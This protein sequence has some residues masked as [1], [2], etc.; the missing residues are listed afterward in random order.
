MLWNVAAPFF[1]G[2]SIWIDDF[3]PAGSFDFAKIAAPEVQ[4]GDWHVRRTRAT[5]LT[6]WA[7]HW[8][9]AKRALGADG[10]VTVFPQLAATANIQRRLFRRNIPMVA[11]CFNI[12]RFPHGIERALVRSAFRGIERI[13]VHSRAEVRLVSDLVGVAGDTVQFVPLQRAPIPVLEEEDQTAPFIV[14]MG[15]AN[16]D[17]ATLF[18]A[19]RRSRLPLTVVASAVA[20]GD[21]RPPANVTLL[22]GL[23]AE[24][25]WRL[26]QRARFSIVPLR[27]VAIASGQVTVIEAMRMNRAVI[28]TVSIG[29]E[30]YIADGVTGVLVP[31]G[32]AAALADRMTLL[33]D[34]RDRRARLARQA[35]DFAEETLSDRS[36]A[37]ALVRIMREA[38]RV[39][40]GRAG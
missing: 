23:T 32:D 14:S 10:L 9:H 5:P 33:W 19:A 18:E 20:I 11:W 4:A 15:S 37:A 13:V 6:T 22:S 26:A 30:D 27:D 39:H 36:A 2:D 17:Y 16:R 25:C 38:Q 12:G 1:R 31:A 29:T 40:D 24:Q 8:R 28:A 35:A 7:G 21:L 3:A 34:D